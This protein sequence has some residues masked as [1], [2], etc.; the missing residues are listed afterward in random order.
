VS[1]IKIFVIGLGVVITV[2]VSDQRQ[3]KFSGG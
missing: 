2:S 3:E 1:Q